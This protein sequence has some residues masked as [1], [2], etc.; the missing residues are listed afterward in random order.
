MS[1]QRISN[2]KVFC[3]S[4]LT[5]DEHAITNLQFNVVL[6]FK[7]SHVILGFLALKQLGIVIH[8]SLNTFHMG[9]CM[10]NCNRESRRISC[11]IVDS[12]KMNKIIV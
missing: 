7:S 11:M 10:I 5:I 1:E 8:P 4:V 6:H 12:D 3:P 9:N 2:T